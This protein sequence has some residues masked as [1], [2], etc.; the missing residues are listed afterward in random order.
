M[1]AVF[2]EIDASRYGLLTEAELDVITDAIANGTHARADRTH[3]RADG[4]HGLSDS[5]ADG[6]AFACANVD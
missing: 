6:R 1:Q 5:S 2:L 3:A 4:S